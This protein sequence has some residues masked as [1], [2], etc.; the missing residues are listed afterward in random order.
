MAL[1]LNVGIIS[2]NMLHDIEEM[3]KSENINYN[4][5]GYDRLVIVT[6][7]IDSAISIT[8]NLLGICKKYKFVYESMLNI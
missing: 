4:H 5:H 7:N 1:E 2:V 8:E 6:D 3:L